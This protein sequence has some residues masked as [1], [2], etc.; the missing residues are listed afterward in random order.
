M[1][2]LIYTYILSDIS[3]FK[4]R[5]LAAADTVA[6]S[7]NLNL[8][9]NLPHQSIY[10]NKEVDKVCFFL[11]FFFKWIYVVCLSLVHYVPSYPFNNI[12]LI[13]QSRY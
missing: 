3:F 2:V 4:N 10:S 11:I 12:S 5:R 9:F 13:I 6:A 7:G 1:H 8:D